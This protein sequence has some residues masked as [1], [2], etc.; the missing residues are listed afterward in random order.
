MS[1]LTGYKT[2]LTIGLAWV[3]A[4]YQYFVEPIPGVD[5]AA[6]ALATTTIALG[7]RKVTSGPPASL[8]D[9]LGLAWQFATFF[10]KSDP[11][12]PGA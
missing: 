5:P 10:H 2:Y 9:L 6:F 1:K 4:L 7:L 3:C 8:K 12:V 11:P